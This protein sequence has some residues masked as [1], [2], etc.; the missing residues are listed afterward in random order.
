MTGRRVAFAVVAAAGLAAG[1]HTA[2]ADMG[3]AP[4]GPPGIYISF[5]GGYLYH[6]A[7]GVIGHGIVLA[8]GGDPQD[9]FVSADDGYFFGGLIGFE[10]GTP[11]LFGFHRVELYFLYGNADDGRTDTAP[12]LADL[13][14][15][16]V[17]GTVLVTGGGTRGKTETERETWEGA[18]RFEDDDGINQTTTVTWV[19]APF[20][21]N[22]DESTFSFVEGG[23]CGG[24]CVARRNGDV[25]TWLYGVYVA[26]EPETWL[27]PNLALVARLGAGVYGYD[28]DG[29]FRSS[30]N[31]APPPDFFAANVKDGDSGVGFRGLFGIGLKFKLAP[32]ANFEAFGE[33]DYFSDV[34]TA[35]MSTN[36]QNTFV[37]HVDTDDLWELRA[38]IRLTLGLGPAPD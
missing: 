11:F 31:A 36:Q 15:T 24:P 21:R 26:V 34:G 8:P 35:H 37:S 16:S 20:I 19:F 7:D 5:E 22:F 9:I 13:A 23:V 18:L 6:D 38:G 32:N 17:D 33:A 4:V 2:K 14:L 12:P 1:S 25:D 3:T 30:S 27:T 29:K 10:N 28:S